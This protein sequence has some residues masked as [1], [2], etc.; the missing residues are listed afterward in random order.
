M[1]T[2]LVS[3]VAVSAC[4]RGCVRVC[5]CPSAE[6][7]RLRGENEKLQAALSGSSQRAN[8]AI[9]S[10]LQTQDDLATARAQIASLT[11]RAPASWWCPVVN[12][13]S[14]SCL[15]GCRFGGL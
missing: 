12:P 9:I 8:D 3:C 5:A 11:V 13:P 7:A 14:S 6:A 2:S 1:P 10:E 4:L 15:C